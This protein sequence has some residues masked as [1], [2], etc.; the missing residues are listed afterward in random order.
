M[1]FSADG[2]HVTTSSDDGTARVW[3][4]QTGWEEVI[5]P[6]T[7]AVLSAQFADDSRRVLT[8]SAGGDVRMWSIDWRELRTRSAAALPHA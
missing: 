8:A 6:H 2:T 3:N 4:S 5:L 7:T 1:I